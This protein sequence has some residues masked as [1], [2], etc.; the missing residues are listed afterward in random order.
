MTTNP[1][2]YMAEYYKRKKNG[3]TN[4]EIY[5]KN[6]KAREENLKRKKIRY[7]L[8]KQGRVK[9]FDGKEID[10]IKP[11]SV[12]GGNSMSNVRVVSFAKNRGRKK[13]STKA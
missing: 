7:E 6:P 8:E 1:K 12:G 5:H 4:A 11:I 9:K 13:K 3:K 10:H 2:G